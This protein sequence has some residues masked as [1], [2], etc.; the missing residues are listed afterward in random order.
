M[1]S[2][3]RC[4]VMMTLLLAASGAR[5]GAVIVGPNTKV[6]SL[7]AEAVKRVFLGREANLGGAPTQVVFHKTGSLRDDFDTSVLGKPG[8]QLTS[9]WSKLVFTGKA[10][11]P[12]ELGSDAEVKAK[13]ASTPGAIGYI[14]D[15][16]VDASVKKVF[17]F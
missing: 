8:A 12:H 4:A 1:T 14:Q 11:A 5:A 3:L 7:E 13:V 2:Q 17:S 10:K 9:Y 6:D 16:A 15:S